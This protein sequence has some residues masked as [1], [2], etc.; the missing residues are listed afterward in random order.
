MA[1]L[2]GPEE[3]YA[4]AEKQ[5]GKNSHPVGKGKK[6]GRRKKRRSAEGTPRRR[7]WK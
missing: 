5:V 1:V 6:L 3:G 4:T 2:E 7:N